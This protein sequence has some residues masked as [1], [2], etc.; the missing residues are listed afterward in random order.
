VPVDR[1]ATVAGAVIF[2]GISDGHIHEVLVQSSGYARQDLTAAAGAPKASIF[3]QPRGFVRAFD[4]RSVVY[5]VDETGRVIELARE[6]GVWRWYDLGYHAG[7]APKAA[8]DSDVD[9]FRR[10][11]GGWGVVYISPTGG[12]HELSFWGDWWHTDLTAK[13]LG[14]APAHR[15][16]DGYVDGSG[17]SAVAY[18]GQDGRVHDLWKGGSTWNAWYHHDV[19]T[20]AG[21]PKADRERSIAAY[22][23][24]GGVTVIAYSDASWTVREL[25]WGPQ[26]YWIHQSL[27]LP[28]GIGLRPLT[29]SSGVTNLIYT[30][31]PDRHIRRAIP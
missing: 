28:N 21:A 29:Y 15:R 5:Y 19:T 31:Y 30:S 27:G 11:D 10:A 25:A 2:A 18:V 3:S 26:P 23:R 7:G 8:T 16:L 22:A 9:A 4:N 20:L 17:F 24:P 14:A 12:V 1:G 13:A 6:A